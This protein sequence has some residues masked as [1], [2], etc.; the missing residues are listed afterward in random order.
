MGTWGTGWFE[1]DA[2]ADFLGDI[3]AVAPAGRSALLLHRLR[4]VADG[5]DDDEGPDADE[6]LAA[7]ALIAIAGG[8]DAGTLAPNVELPSGLPSPD[9]SLLA[10]ARAAVT[11]LAQPQDNEWLELWAEAG[12]QKL[13]LS[14]LAALQE[15]LAAVVPAVGPAAASTAPAG[16]DGGRRRWWRRR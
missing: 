3:E 12:Q 6:A 11:R 7:A 14:R 1:N 13:A 8:A 10:L 5:N 2:A 9:A 15:Q 16:H 4:A